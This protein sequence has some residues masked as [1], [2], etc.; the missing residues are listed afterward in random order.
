MENLKREKL[1]MYG[2]KCLKIQNGRQM[3]ENSKR[4]LNVRRQMSEN[5]NG[6]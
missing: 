3:S 1:Q 6:R 2:E 5:P 4:A